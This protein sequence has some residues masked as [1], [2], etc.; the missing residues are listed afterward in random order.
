L[1][2]EISAAN[3]TEV[4]MREPVRE[5]IAPIPQPRG[6]PRKWPDHLHAEQAYHARRVRQDVRRRSIRVRSARRGIES[7]E[8]L[9][10]YRWIVERTLA[11]RQRY[12][13]LTVRDARRA[14]IHQA[15]LSLGCALTC[16]NFLQRF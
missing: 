12:R 3:G 13:R 7:R 10:R 5:A 16:W 14:E 2:G 9:G 15:F 11:G 6:R 1:A 4:T 8:R